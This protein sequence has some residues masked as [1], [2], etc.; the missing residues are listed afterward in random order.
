LFSPNSS[1]EVLLRTIANEKG[2]GFYLCAGDNE[3][4]P[5]GDPNLLNPSPKRTVPSPDT[6]LTD[7]IG[8]D[9]QCLCDYLDI[10]PFCKM[11]RQVP[12]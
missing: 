4:Q 11:Q 8:R 7:R 5:I 9:S 1:V 3:S 10:E 12:V 6:F 2:R